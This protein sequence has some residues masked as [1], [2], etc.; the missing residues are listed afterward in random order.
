VSPPD[1]RTI[2]LVLL[3]CAVLMTVTLSL[4]I[5]GSRAPGLAKWNLGQALYAAGWLLLAARDALPGWLGIAVADGLLL[6]GLCAQI[7]GLK[8]FGGRSAP[9]WLWLPGALLA[10]LVVPLLH[11]YAA[12][13][14]LTSSAYSAAFA[15]LAL[16]TL[17]LGQR[18]GPVRWLSA[19]VL[20][21]GAVLLMARAVDIALDPPAAGVF[22][23][24]TLHALAFVSLF[25]VTVTSSF[26][27]LVM[28]RERAEQALRHLA[29]NDPLTG[30]LNR[31]AFLDLAERES[32]RCAR[33][34]QA[35][36]VLML[37]LDHFKRVND[38]H[39]HQAGDRVLA[40]FGRRLRQAV[41][42]ADLV[43]RYG[44]EEFCVLLPGAG[45]AEALAIAERAR[46]AVAAA[47]LDALPETVTVSVGVATCAGAPRPSLD[48][49]I[50]R[51]DSALYAAKGLGRNRV[52][53]IQVGARNGKQAARFEM[54]QTAQPAVP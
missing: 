44:G 7:A 35:V 42:T 18:A 54:G 23:Q 31:G 6:Q 3:L 15:A 29:M 47:P 46:A 40:E 34:G 19:A 17:R 32:A 27:F 14:F 50:G 45:H 11:S 52:L 10:L 1:I 28:H 20:C 41:R 26:A 21:G 13:T 16:L 4:G 37:D 25:A 49:L 9:R 43:G 22:A 8:E 33:Q 38:S 39:G 12:L 24:S 30:T 36:A 2:V 48:F 53:G 51:A 5:R